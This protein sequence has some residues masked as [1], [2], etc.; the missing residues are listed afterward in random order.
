MKPSGPE[1]LCAGRFRSLFPFL[2]G[3]PPGGCWGGLCFLSLRGG[4]SGTVNMGGFE[5]CLRFRKSNIREQIPSIYLVSYQL[6]LISVCLPT[7][8]CHHSATSTSVLTLRGAPETCGQ[9]GLVPR[10]PEASPLTC[11]VIL[12][13]SLSEVQEPPGERGVLAHLYLNAKLLESPQYTD[14][15]GSTL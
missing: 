7:V 2:L 13:V 10:C 8:I 4:S 12:G 14:V 3:L 1:V 9:R 5:F 6:S 11:S 15:S